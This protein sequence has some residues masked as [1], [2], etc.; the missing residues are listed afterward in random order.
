MNGI[1]EK[2]TYIKTHSDPSVYKTFTKL[3]DAWNLPGAHN[4]KGSWIYQD[5]TDQTNK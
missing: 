2:R 5:M 1:F 3:F 4:K